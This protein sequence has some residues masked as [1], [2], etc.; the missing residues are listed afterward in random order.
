MRAVVVQLVQAAPPEPQVPGYDVAG[1]VDA[2][3]EGVTDLAVGDEVLGKARA[4][5]R[6]VLVGYLPVGCPSVQESIEAMVA[7]VLA[8]LT[9]EK[10]GG[11]SVEETR[12]NHAAYVGRLVERGLA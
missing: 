10:F 4:D 6:A 5:D 2:V 1:V 9:L 11:D 3:G 8:E 12:R 7:L